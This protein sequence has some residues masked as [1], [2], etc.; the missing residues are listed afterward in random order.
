MSLSFPDL[1]RTFAW[2]RNVIQSV[3]PENI[4]TPRGGQRK[5]RGKGGIQNEAISEGVGMA[6]RVFF[7]EAPSTIDEQDISYFVFNQCFKAKIIFYRW[8]F[9]CRQLSVFF[10]YFHGF[11]HS[12]L[13]YVVTRLSSAH[14]WTSGYL[15]LVLLHNILWYLM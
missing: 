14:G 10:F 1:L 7:P 11:H 12:L 4:H 3:V 5:F 15:S 2:V 13:V 6:T 9:I 8:S